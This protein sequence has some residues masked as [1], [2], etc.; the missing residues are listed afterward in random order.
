MERRKAGKEL[1]KLKQLQDDQELRQLKEDRAREKAEE[2]EARRRVLEQIKMDR[3]QR[4]QRL[5][6]P[7]VSPVVKPYTPPAPRPMANLP[8]HT[9]IQFRKPTGESIVDTFKSDG[10]FGDVWKYAQASVVDGSQNFVLATAMPPR[11]EFSA[12]DSQKTLIEL[13]LAPSA[14]L[15]VIPLSGGG[16]SGGRTSA[17][18]L[19]VFNSF[20]L[21]LFWTVVTPFLNLWSRFMN[22]NNNTSNTSTG[23]SDDAAAGDVPGPSSLNISSEM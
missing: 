1:A 12:E 15:L 8:D 16:G 5:D 14:V 22:R 20:L 4:Q 17:G 11:Q 19:A 10:Y 23:R 9:R 13:N 6:Q 2:D 21:T 3:L 7:A 18:P